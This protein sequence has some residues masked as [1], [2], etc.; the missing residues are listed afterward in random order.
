MME[1]RNSGPAGPQ[2]N[3]GDRQ[4]YAEAPGNEALHCQSVCS[5]KSDS[6]GDADECY[7]DKLSFRHVEL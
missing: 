5:S 3:S 6:W 4:R 2:A 7:K 1:T